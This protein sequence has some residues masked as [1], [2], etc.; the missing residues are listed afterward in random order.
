M[1][2]TPCSISC[3]HQTP[4]PRKRPAPPAPYSRP[5]PSGLTNTNKP[6]RSSGVTSSGHSQHAFLLHVRACI[7]LTHAAAGHTSWTVHCPVP[8]ST[9]PSGGQ[10]PKPALVSCLHHTT[11]NR[12]L[13]G[14][15]VLTASAPA[16]YWMQLHDTK[17]YELNYCI[18]PFGSGGPR[19]RGR[20]CTAAPT[21]AAAAAQAKRHA[22][23]QN[24]MERGKGA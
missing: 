20:V 6:P 15:S 18:T 7:K 9:R 17:C 11:S 12:L 3:T 2:P 5:P 23:S 10:A 14:T 21:S 22:Q 16:L 1:S 4:W 8:N 24:I 13:L 19:A